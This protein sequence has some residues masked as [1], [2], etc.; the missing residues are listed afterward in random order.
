MNITQVNVGT[1]ANDGTGDN[2]RAAFVK[3][4][5]NFNEVAAAINAYQ[6]ATPVAGAS[7]VITNDPAFLILEPSA[8]LATL[9]VTLPSTPSDGQVVRIATT[10]AVT[11]LTLRGATGQTVK[12]AVTTLAAGAAVTFLYRSANSSWYKV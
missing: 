3:I 7:I 1:V 10:A 9:T 2:I 11:A 5:S 8:T 6:Y 4:N 12:T